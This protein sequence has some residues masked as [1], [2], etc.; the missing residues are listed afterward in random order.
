VPVCLHRD[1]GYRISD[2][3]YNFIPISDIMSDS[4]LSVRYLKFGYQAQSD[5]AD[6]GYRT[7]CPPMD[8]SHIPTTPGAPPSTIENQEEKEIQPRNKEKVKTDSDR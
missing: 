1:V 6:H 7:K 8:I 5:I 4:T 2:I 3:R